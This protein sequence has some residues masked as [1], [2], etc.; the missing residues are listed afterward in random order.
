MKYVLCYSGGLD[1]TVMLFDLM[2]ENFIYAIGFDYGQRHKRELISA[3]QIANRYGIIFKV[4]EMETLKQFFGASSQT[5]ERIAV[6]HGHYA[7]EN[8][9]L[10]V[11]PNRNMIMLSIASAFAISTQSKAVCYSAHAG[12]HTIYP[13]CRPEFME[14]LGN[15]IKIC[16]W[17]PVELYAPYKNMT[18][19]EIVKRGAELKVPFE[20]TW[21]CY[22]G[23]LVHCGKCGTCV[24]RKEAF[25][26]A[27]VKDPTEYKE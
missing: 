8:M 15:A 23:G 25:A 26:L 4:A 5:D 17:H 20:M 11:V 27:G 7:D 18:K 13:D 24:E 6:P 19:A 14:H 3:A 16:D 21:S 1:S 22:E 10:T 2:Q 9:K 12:D